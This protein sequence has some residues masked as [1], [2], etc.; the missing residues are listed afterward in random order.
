LKRA[1]FEHL[2]LYKQTFNLLVEF[3]KLISIFPK[4][5]KFAIGVPII[6]DLTNSIIMIIEVN[7]KKEKIEKLNELILLFEKIK[8]QI[9]LLK[10]LEIISKQLYFNLSDKI[11]QIL[12][13][14]EG[15]KKN[16]K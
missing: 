5:Y 4:K 1:Q 9:R 14:C 8:L 16:V 10:S 7:N 3:H 2:P 6:N 15:W 11:I 12:K 13:Q